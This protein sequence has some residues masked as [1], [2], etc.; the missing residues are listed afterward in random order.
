MNNLKTLT[1]QRIVI[2]CAKLNSLSPH[3]LFGMNLQKTFYESN[4]SLLI[5]FDINFEFCLYC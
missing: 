4:Q 5:N 1:R 2:V 3:D